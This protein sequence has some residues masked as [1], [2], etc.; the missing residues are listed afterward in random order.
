[1]NKN[2]Y[3]CIGDGDNIGDVLTLH[4]LCNQ[5]DEASKFSYKVKYAIEKIA[6]DVQK[7]MN[8]N[9]IYVAGDDIC[10]TFFYHDD[11]LEKLTNYSQN[12]LQI[13]GNTISFGVARNSIDASVC[14]RKAKVSGKGRVIISE[15]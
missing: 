14:L 3:I 7:E 6:K 5:V 11:F 8:A 10:F 2:L 12:F 15:R 9:I 4:L 1:M 13:T